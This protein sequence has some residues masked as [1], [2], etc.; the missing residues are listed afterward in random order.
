[1]KSENFSVLQPATIKR[2]PGLLSSIYNSNIYLFKT[3]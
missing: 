1:M 3:Q 2:Y